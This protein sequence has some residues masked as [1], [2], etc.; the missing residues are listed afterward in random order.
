MRPAPA[1][2]VPRGLVVLLLACVAFGWWQS[3]TP[4]VPAAV[5]GD[6]RPVDC[7]V[8]G[9]GPA[10]TLGGL[11]TPVQRADAPLPPAFALGDHRVQPRAAFA[12]EA[13]VLGERRYRFGAESAISPLD[14]ALGWGQMAVP[15]VYGA[16][17]IS[18]SGRWY[19]YR[20]GADGP[21]IPLD[22]IVSQSSNMHMVPS[23]DAVA[24]R[25]LELDAG[26]RVR[27][28]GWLVDVESPGRGHWRTS[29]R[30]DDSGDGACEIVY[31]CDVAA[32]P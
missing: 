6:G 15:A 17:D 1:L 29:M 10:S 21:P 5:G 7:R 19:H 30:R 16:L 26:E 32:V 23:S 9:W 20:W 28:V 22:A 25:L 11:S 18:Q 2:P 3:R 14:L 31:V 12:L 4:P 24:R 8:P 13:T 27:L